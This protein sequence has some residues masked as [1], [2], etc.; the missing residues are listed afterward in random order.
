M[1]AFVLALVSGNEVTG[2]DP[3]QNFPHNG[4]VILGRSDEGTTQ[5]G[6]SKPMAHVPREG[7]V[8]HAR[9][10]GENE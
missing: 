2:L 7:M 10:S 8:R 5:G 9:K 3:L 4:G 6:G 1:G